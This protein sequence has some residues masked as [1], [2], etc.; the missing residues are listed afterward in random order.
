MAV[1]TM[2]LALMLMALTLVNV[3]MD[4]QE[5]DSIALV[6]TY[7][8]C[9]SGNHYG[10]AL[11]T[12]FSIYLKKDIIVL[13]CNI[14]FGKNPTRKQCTI[15]CHQVSVPDFGLEVEFLL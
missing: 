14:C 6:S 9:I 8:F 11:R 3:K 5:M 13:L 12:Y 1:M 10:V 15:F 4:L 7:N 2:P